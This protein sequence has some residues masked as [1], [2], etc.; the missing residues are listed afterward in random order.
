VQASKQSIRIW[1]W[2][3]RANY[4]VCRITY[5]TGILRHGHSR[6]ERLSV[7]ARRLAEC[8]QLLTATERRLETVCQDGV[9]RSAVCSWSIRLQSKCLVW[10]MSSA[11]WAVGVYI[12]VCW[13]V[14]AC[15]SYRTSLSH[16]FFLSLLR[17]SLTIWSSGTTKEPTAGRG[18]GTMELSSEF[19]CW[20]SLC[21]LQWSAWLATSSW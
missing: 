18:G 21:P 20:Y 15:I 6:C 3:W 5:T 19:P 1:I 11:S 9:Q 8:T 17:R 14:D 12:L 2:I 7:W 4:R 13:V 16:S 10:Y